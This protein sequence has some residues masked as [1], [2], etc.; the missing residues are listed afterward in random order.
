V[1]DDRYTV[2]AAVGEGGMA[3]VYR[4]RHRK[5]GST[6]ALKVLNLPAVSIRERLMAEGRVQATLRHRNVVAVTDVVE[7]SGAPGLIMEYIDG[8]TL[9]SLLKSH[10]MTIEQADVLGRG[11]IAGV[12]AAHRYDLVHR[13]LKPANVLLAVTD[14]GLVPKVADFGL[15]KI[16]ASDGDDSQTRS[17]ASMGTP[18]YMA[19]E[20]IRDSKSVDR[21]ADIFSLG[22]M[23]YELV[24][25]RRAFDG[26]DM[27]E[28]FNSICQGR[29]T[30]PGE[31]VSDL[32][33]PMSRAI[34]GALQVE[35]D[36]RIGS[37]GELLATWKGEVFDPNQ[38]EE[39][40]SGPWSGSIIADASSLGSG[41]SLDAE[42]IS[43]RAEATDM[44][45]EEFG[46]SHRTD[47]MTVYQGLQLA[48]PAEND[49][50]LADV[51]AAMPRQEDSSA[52]SPDSA[53]TLGHDELGPGSVPV[54]IVNAAEQPGR[55][56]SRRW[57][58]LGGAVVA[59]VVALSLRGS[60][61]GPEIGESSSAPEAGEAPGVPGSGAEE[62]EVRNPPVEVEQP[63]VL[64]G[65]AQGSG[66]EEVPPES[67][68]KPVP[69]APRVPADAGLAPV[70]S[71]PETVELEP[72]G[73][74]RD[75][76]P[77]GTNRPDPSKATVQV[78]GDVQRVWLVGDMGRHP[79]GEVPPGTY[80]VQA[81]FDEGT[82]VVTG[83]ITVAAGET[84]T[85]TCSNALL[86]CR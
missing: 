73:S 48:A 11:I 16:L 24:C 39:P 57:I 77:A 80:T 58:A 65:E 64:A 32:P 71:E 44:W 66:Q 21:R 6:H 23:L 31:L 1:V 14:E 13:D 15:A 81:F 67:R 85:L 38:D 78:Q 74:V 20:Q 22:A 76:A 3:T 52:S 51:V 75:D 30:P 43:T 79:A 83:T 68:A 37:C 29:Y 4:V 46:E 63:V 40:L 41:S 2:E 55:A 54:R 28:I 49:G 27:L 82:P 34:I 19:P 25:G 62:P 9:R 45:L 12:A 8:P 18:Q 42:D 56:S 72:I 61:E 86:A 60:M 84:R 70:G 35:R 7:V 53:E 69:A 36:Q 59:A 50:D 26:A 47:S 33:E 10:R 5:L 17:G